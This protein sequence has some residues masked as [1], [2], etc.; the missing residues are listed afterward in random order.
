MRV[1]HF[2]TPKYSSI[3]AAER[4][5][6]MGFAIFFPIT[7]I[8]FVAINSL[9]VMSVIYV[10]NGL[11]IVMFFFNRYNIPSWARFGVY[12]LIIVQQMFLF[13]LALAG[14][15]D[16]WIDFRKLHKKAS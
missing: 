13:V 9:I 1:D 5:A 11:S 14:L 3:N 6:A 7:K 4:K 15:F 12:A 10:F 16:Q 2:S 8:Q